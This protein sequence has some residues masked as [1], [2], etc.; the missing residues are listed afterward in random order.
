MTLHERFPYRDCEA[1]AVAVRLKKSG[2]GD[3]A[4]Y[5]MLGAILLDIVGIAANTIV[6]EP[7]LSKWWPVIKDLDVQGK[8]V[9]KLLS[10]INEKPLDTDKPKALWSYLKTSA[11]NA[12]RNEV[13]NFKNRFRLAQITPESHLDIDSMDYLKCRKVDIDGFSTK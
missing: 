8:A 7:E 4:M 9:L 12:M 13:R 5:D 1:L 6:K 11:E 2:R 10:V 3:R